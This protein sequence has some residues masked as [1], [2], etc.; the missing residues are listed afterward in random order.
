[1]QWEKEREHEE[2]TESVKRQQGECIKIFQY[3]RKSLSCGISYV[4][5]TF[6][7]SA[8]CRDGATRI[9][10]A[11]FY[12]LFFRERPLEPGVSGSHRERRIFL[13]YSSFV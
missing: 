3:S 12:G 4:S 11:L 7:T 13:G 10:F 5:H 9:L 8:V 1:M 6:Q 2:N